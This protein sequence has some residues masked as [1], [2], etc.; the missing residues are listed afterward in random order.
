[1]LE[2]IKRFLFLVI[3]LIP[4][5]L[6]ADGQTS[7]HASR[8]RVTV[9]DF[10]TIPA[11]KTDVQQALDWIDDNLAAGGA[12]A[13]A[14]KY[15]QF[16]DGGVMGAE[17]TFTYT[18]GTDTLSID[19]IVIGPG[20]ADYAMPTARGAA[21]TYLRDNGG[22]LITFS[23]LSG[24][25]PA[26]F[27]PNAD[28]GDINTG[29]AGDLRFG[30][31]S[32]DNDI[33]NWGN[34]DYLDN[35][36]SIDIDAYAAIGAFA[37]G[38]KFLVYEIGVGIRKADY[39]DLPVGG[40]GDLLADGTIPMTAD[41]EFGN[42]DLTL[43]SLTGDGTIEGATLTEGGNA[44]FNTTEA[45]TFTGLTSSGIVN[46]DDGVGDSPSLFLIDADNKYLA[47]IKYDAGAA[48]LFNNEGAIRLAPSNDTN[49]YIEISTAAGVVTIA[50][51][52]G[53]DGDLVITAGGGDIST[54]STFE[55]A[56]ITEGGNAVYSSGETP[57][58]E[59]GGTYANITIDDNVTVT[60]WVMGAS[61]AT[62]PAENDAD[63]SL[64]TTAWC[65]TTQN[66]LKTSENSDSDDDISDDASTSLTDTAAL[67]YET[68][69][70]EFD[71]LQ[72]QIADKT[73]INTTDNLSVFAATTS[74]QLYGVL[75]DEFS[76]GI[77]ALINASPKLE[78]S[79]MGYAFSPKV[80]GGAIPKRY[81]GDNYEYP[82]MEFTNSA[83]KIAY[84]YP[85]VPPN[86]TGSTVE[87]QLIWLSESV[88]ATHGVSFFV[89]SDSYTDDEDFDGGALAGTEVEIE[90]AATT[91]GDL[92]RSAWTS[93]TCSWEA[94]EEAVVKVT[95]DKDG[96]SGTDL[97]Q[98]VGVYKI[99]IR[100]PISKLEH[101]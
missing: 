5:S 70:D 76:S 60:G 29:A 87:L 53:D 91:D 24:I 62:T 61:T 71:E 54:A 89:D 9:D 75:S 51:T 48:G 101:N 92:M 41:W 49:D 7:N 30:A 56:T 88:T 79:Y 95:R 16:N 43:K 15:V 13:G 35:L 19:R 74:A 36:G 83:D 77:F 69:L 94:G 8:T 31:D 67:L 18:K 80:S 40:S 59:L 26:N 96:Y 22:G 98:P 50:T 81:S 46:I 39:D 21:N 97:E 93:F 4:L 33:I 64:A 90:D 65:E 17:A 45:A 42:Y 47:L 10:G 25:G 55:A 12:P 34:I 57:S 85:T 32:I 72:T 11:T 63:T 82:V 6:M 86:F 14:D 78:L 99:R 3:L 23:A 2:R 66:Y 100:Y 37:S 73:L 27:T 68:E 38:D 84:F 44:V 20:V 1:M 28:F 58:G 52:L